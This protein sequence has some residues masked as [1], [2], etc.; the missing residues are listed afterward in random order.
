MAQQ[1]LETPDI[2]TATYK[3]VIGT[4][5]LEPT[6]FLTLMQ[7]KLLANVIGTGPIDIDCCPA[8][9]LP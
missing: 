1:H 6:I 2:V 5:P 9:Y 4:G 3:G 8:Y 7:W